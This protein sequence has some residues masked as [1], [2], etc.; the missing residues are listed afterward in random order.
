MQFEL[1]AAW[2][3]EAAWKQQSH[4][5]ATYCSI[6]STAATAYAQLIQT[7]GS[8]LSGRPTAEAVLALS[9]GD[10]AHSDTESLI[11]P[12]SDTCGDALAFLLQSAG[13]GEASGTLPQ[14]VTGKEQ[15]MYE[16]V[17]AMATYFSVAGAAPL[18]AP[19]RNLLARSSAKIKSI[20]GAA[21]AVATA[22]IGEQ[23]WAQRPFS[24]DTQPL[25]VLPAPLR[26]IGGSG[27]VNQLLGG[28]LLQQVLPSPRTC[29]SLGFVFQCYGSAG[30]HL[31]AFPGLRKVGGDG[32][33][34]MTSRTGA[35]CV[36][37]RLAQQRYWIGAAHDTGTF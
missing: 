19:Q 28:L 4:R 9:V 16:I 24:L 15:D 8:A 6:V 13:A 17:T 18:T 3:S 29:T 31:K 25:Q 33:C 1:P 27:N 12:T 11:S 32:A 35:S 22:R 34:L 26:W 7:V 21:E 36:S 5:G 14:L 23:A 2:S 20:S 37:C 10:S 30:G